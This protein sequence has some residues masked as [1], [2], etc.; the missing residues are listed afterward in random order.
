VTVRKSWGCD[1]ENSCKETVQSKV[2]VGS[3][4]SDEVFERRRRGE[5]G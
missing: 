3:K 2:D 1:C 4:E 5:S